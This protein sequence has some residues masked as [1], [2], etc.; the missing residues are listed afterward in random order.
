MTLFRATLMMA[1]AA[2]LSACAGGDI[3][4][5]N[6]LANSELL[7][8]KDGE[9]QPSVPLNRSY[10]VV[11]VRVEVPET[12]TSSEDN[13][14]KPRVD[15]LWQEDPAGD[16]HAQV[17]ELMTAALEE[18]VAATEGSR[19]VV[20]DVVMTR[21]HALTKR[22]RYSIGGE[23]E[24]WMYVAVRDAETGELLEP[25][26]RIG[27]DHRISAAQALENEAQGLNQ[28]LEIT[29]LVKDLIR[30]ELT[31]PRDFLQG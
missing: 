10:R 25:A 20:L 16:R 28:R 30:Q 12:L 8:S 9:F 26:R 14:I 3:V 22:T 15:I 4:S 19:D 27:F 6:A 18:G 21:F 7:S 31:R 2:L 24:V 17:R 1:A 13:G 5:R 23:H 11:D 29:A